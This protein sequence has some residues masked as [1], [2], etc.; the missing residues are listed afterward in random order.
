M[1]DKISIRPFLL[2]DKDRLIEIA[3]N[4]NIYT[5]LRD[6]FPHPYT[7]EHAEVFLQKAISARPSQLMAILCNDHYV[8]NIGIH[9]G[10]D[11]YRKS[12]E[13][14]Y[15]ISEDHWNK[16]IATQ[17]VAIM[18]EYTFANFQYVRIYASVFDYNKASAKVLEKNG[19]LFEGSSTKSIYKNGSYY[20]E[21]H[22]ALVR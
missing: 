19:F 12:A 4:R 6:A 20:N 18:V 15:F 3:N 5:N 22:Y 9:P 16:G 11:V 7:S 13:L 8:G 1:T 21:L 10:Q 14:G 17:A 2:T